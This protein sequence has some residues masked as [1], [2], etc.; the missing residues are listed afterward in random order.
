[1]R[2]NGPTHEFS[3]VIH[4]LND[5]IYRPKVIGINGEGVRFIKMKRELFG[6]GVVEKDEMRYSGLGKTL[7]DMVYPSR[8][9]SVSEERISINP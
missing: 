1:M 4:V 3:P 6:F 8:Y 9:R 7:L 2:L 5:A